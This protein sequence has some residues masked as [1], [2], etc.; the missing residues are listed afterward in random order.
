MTSLVFRISCYSALFFQ[1]EDLSVF[2]EKINKT[3][4]NL[5]IVIKG[6]FRSFQ[7]VVLSFIPACCVSRESVLQW[8]P[9]APPLC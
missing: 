5:I 2:Y 3:M 4:H 8:Q 7:G 1:S 6:L 9:F